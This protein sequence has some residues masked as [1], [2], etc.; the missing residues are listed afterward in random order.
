MESRDAQPLTEAAYYILLSLH[1]PRHGYGIMQFVREMSRERVNLG[2]GTL[3]GALKNMTEKGWIEPANAE[4]D[5]RRKE[6]VITG[7]G[8]ETAAA[9]LERLRELVSG[10]LEIM[11]RNRD[12]RRRAD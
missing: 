4:T 2:P 9:E 11:G 7:L 6:Y 5:G 10:G 12:E 8:R 3:Y 1:E